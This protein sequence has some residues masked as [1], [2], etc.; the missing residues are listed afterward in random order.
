[1]K[2]RRS[3]VVDRR[4]VFTQRVVRHRNRMPREIVDALSVEASKVRLD[5]ALGSLI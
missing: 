4:K 3:R 2:E 1:M 5:G